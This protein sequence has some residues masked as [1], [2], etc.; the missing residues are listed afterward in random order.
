[1]SEALKKESGAEAVFVVLAEVMGGNPCRRG[2]QHRSRRRIRRG[3]V[4]YRWA[5]GRQS[6]PTIS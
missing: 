4:G 5:S 1:L 3:A 2:L 6:R